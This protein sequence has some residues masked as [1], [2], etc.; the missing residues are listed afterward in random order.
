MSISFGG[1]SWPISADDMNLGTVGQGFCLGGIFD[2]GLGSNIGAGGGN[3]EPD[4]HKG[5]A[6]HRTSVSTA[7]GGEREKT[8]A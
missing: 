3:R 1:K 4:H 6:E 7:R 2:L 5:E 8:D